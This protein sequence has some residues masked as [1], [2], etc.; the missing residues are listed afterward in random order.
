MIRKRANAL[1]ILK[2]YY[3]GLEI[4]WLLWS[5]VSS[6]LGRIK[7]SRIKEWNRDQPV[8]VCAVASLEGSIPV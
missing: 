4:Q 6:R 1:S 8:K 5:N 2:S 7:V 3:M